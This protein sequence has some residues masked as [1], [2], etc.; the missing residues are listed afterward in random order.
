MP[1]S[2]STMFGPRHWPAGHMF[3][4][5]LTGHELHGLVRFLPREANEAEREGR[6]EAA[7]AL[8][9]RAAALREAAR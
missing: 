9:W 1:Y 7:D 3:R 6:I 5:S 8:H 4:V 2:V